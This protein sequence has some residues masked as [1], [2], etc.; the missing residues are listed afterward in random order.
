MAT[1]LSPRINTTSGR[2]LGLLALRLGVGASVLH[3]SLKKLFSLQ[4]TADSMEAGGWQSP[5]LATYMVTFAE[6][7]GGIGLILGLLTPL[8]ALAV[9]AA[10]LDAWAVNIADAAVWT[11]PFN[12]PFVIATGALAVL[13]TGAGRHS[14]DERLWGRGSWP[15]P[16][17]IVLLVVAVAAAVATWVLLN[18]TNPIHLTATTG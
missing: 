5:Q 17:S 3:P 13:F 18:G 2:D 6:A 10:M 12:L 9:L 7:A 8:A 11:N 1:E 15:R 4:S 14:V 16:V